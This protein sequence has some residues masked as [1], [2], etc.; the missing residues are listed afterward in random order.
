M[1]LKKC[2]WCGCIP[3]INLTINPPSSV[4]CKITTCLVK[5]T[6]YGRDI[7]D[8]IIRWNRRYDDDM[9]DPEN[10]E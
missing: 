10:H 3:V 4:T 8:A 6:A 9:S 7:E 2:P 5:P 1:D